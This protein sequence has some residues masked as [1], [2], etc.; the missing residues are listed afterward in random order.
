MARAGRERGGKYHI[1]CAI[2]I[3][4][5]VHAKV[6]MIAMALVTVRCGASAGEER[7]PAALSVHS[8]YVRKIA[9]HAM[10]NPVRSCGQSTLKIAKKCEVQSRNA[11]V[12]Q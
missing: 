3:V 5:A 8:E 11:V 9:L 12:V 1:T 7:T 2:H 6:A 10:C 4:D